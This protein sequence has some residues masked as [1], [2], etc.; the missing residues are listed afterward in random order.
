MFKKINTLNGFDWSLIAGITVLNIIYSVLQHEAD[1]SGI[2]A[3]VSGVICVVLV[4][5]GNILNYVFGII[6]VT[7]YAWI[8]WKAKL[9]GDAALNALYYLPMQFAGWI[10]WYRKREAKDSVTVVTKLMNRKQRIQLAVSSLLLT[11]LTGFILSLT[12]DPQPYKDSATTVLSV[13]AM[14]IMVR[15]YTEQWILWGI[16]NIISIIMWVSLYLRGTEHSAF[17][18][19]M[20]IAYLANSI[21]GWIV[22]NRLSGRENESKVLQ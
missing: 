5:K 1:L 12:G 9:Y 7:L 19:L 15:A 18:V 16:V 11:M 14:Y 20:W 10:V 17:M 13:I 2:T 3:A 21:N 6:N 8:S 22:W 4:A